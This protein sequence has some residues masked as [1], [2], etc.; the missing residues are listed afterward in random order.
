MKISHKGKRIRRAIGNT[1]S[2]TIS[3]ARAYVMEER[4]RLLMGEESIS[5]IKA[6]TDDITVPE[7]IAHFKAHHFPKLKPRTIQTYELHLN[8]MMGRV[9]DLEAKLVDK[10]MARQLKTQYGKG[11]ASN[12]F[13]VTLSKCWDWGI[14]AGYVFENP[15]SGVDH[16]P[17]KPRDMMADEEQ[18]KAILNSIRQEEPRLKAYHLLILLTCS[19]RGE[20]DKMR[21]KD[22]NG[23]IWLKTD[24]KNK[25]GQRV[26]V[27]QEALEAIRELPM[28]NREDLVFSGFQ[29]FSRAWKRIL[30]RAGLTYPG[31]RVHDL[32][33]SVATMLLTQRKATVD[34]ISS[35]LGHSSVAIT[36]KVYAKYLGDNRETVDAVSDMLN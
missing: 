22:I 33:R 11:P 18:L 21:W 6:P 16:V 19:R 34:Q 10:M 24:T 3:D 5:D 32:R 27:P 31:I 30:N 36:Q 20:A 28:N 13:L 2:I 15:W 29:G 12:R 35:M 4:R 9:G 17:E 25:K 7:L 8:V 26:V 23:D 14:K 1:K